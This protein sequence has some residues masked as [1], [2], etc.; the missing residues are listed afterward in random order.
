[1]NP[2]RWKEI[3]RLY[4]S[5]LDFP[6][7]RRKEF[8]AQSCMGDESLRREVER[9]LDSE[10]EA[11]TFIERPAIEILAKGLA[12]N[13]EQFKSTRSLIG[14]SLGR[15][16]IAGLLG[17]G[18]MGEVY[19]AKDQILGRNVAIKVL[20][21]EFARDPERVARFKREAKLLASLNHPNIAAIYGLEES[22]E[23]SF[24]VLELVE[25][26]TL[27]DRI[28]AGSFSVQYA[29]N[30]ALQITE[31]LEAAHEKGII[32]RDLKPANIKVTPAGQVKILDFGLA[33]ALAGAP[34]ELNPSNSITLSSAA[35]QHGMIL[36]T[37]SYVSPEQARGKG[38]DKKADI[39]S[40]GCVLFEMLAGRTAFSGNDFT[41]V[42][43]AVIRSEPD[44]SGLPSKLHWRLREVLERCL[45]KESNNRYH[46]ISDVRLDLRKILAD[47][48][49]L[50]NPIAAEKAPKG[51]GIL[52]IAAAVILIL[53]LAVPVARFLRSN[54][55]PQVIRFSYELP[56]DQELGGLNLTEAMLAVS[57]DGKRWVHC[58]RGG[59]YLHT[60]DEMDAKLI[61]GTEG[62]PQQP[63][64][65][66][67]GERIGYWSAAERRL[68]TISIRGGMPANLTSDLALGSL[69]WNEDA[70]LYSTVEGLKSISLNGEIKLLVKSEKEP[71]FT[72]RLLP[73]G[74]AMIFTIGTDND[75][76][77]AVYSLVSKKYKI[78]APGSDAYYS[79]TGQLLYILDR[80]LV[81]T[82]FD[83]DT[84][85]LSGRYAPIVKRV[86][87]TTG[88]PQFA[89]SAAGTI[90]YLPE[91]ST[92][93]WPRRT[94]CWVD[95][96]GREEPLGVE[97]NAYS[98]PR[99]S[100]DGRRVSL[101]VGSLSNINIK[102]L[103]LAH[104]YM[105]QQTSDNQINTLPLW[106]P[107]GKGIAFYRQTKAN[108]EVH[109]ME[110]N[111]AETISPY[112]LQNVS[113]LPECWVNENTF[114]ATA[115]QVGSG[116]FQIGKLS[117]EGTRTWTPLISRALQ[118]QISPNGQWLAY[119]S[120]ESGRNEIWV[121]PFPG[122]HSGG[123]WQVSTGGGDSPLWAPDGRELFY[124][125]GNQVMAA[126]IETSPGFGYGVAK[127]LFQG[128]YTPS[129]LRVGSYEQ[130]HTWDISPDGKRFLMMKDEGNNSSAG[131]GPR[132]INVVLNLFEEL[133]Q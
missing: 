103:E 82:P 29:L 45:D 84:L 105:T 68:K 91:I 120:D 52:W 74:K 57:P 77:I 18:G 62:N 49:G 124:R 19:E 30:L 60:M 121:R 13:A 31:A 69:S 43:A 94:L 115:S 14:Q 66:P 110:V 37:A 96:N 130:L 83:I 44:W 86:L 108:F 117:M 12:A 11:E 131:G 104:G 16:Q 81:A 67:D 79:P 47:P 106:T 54:A 89:L 78:L 102:I 98:N 40:F 129:D 88:A 100:R 21:E 118:P 95:G 25:G 122:I 111:G 65:S 70:I 128:S 51:K 61:P 93:N 53:I 132:K 133:K 8:L 99:I 71:F 112:S 107:D 35:T 101:S 76:R 15:Y 50:I 126:P 10:L 63:F 48:G 5:A 92:E 42:L 55:L 116:Y 85:S 17:K 75:Y 80:D 127:V 73:G 26:D 87:R 46:D 113:I 4:N 2:E 123:R 58:T 3:E 125:S 20:P 38:V 64:F 114:L 6:P 34:S 97:P 28:K 41:D 27:A 23:I 119:T 22:G 32:H 72:P 33:K 109:F 24:L 9:M 90:V 36:G 59:I 56:K 1:M 7:D 39:W